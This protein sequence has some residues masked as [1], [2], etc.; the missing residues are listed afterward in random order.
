[1]PQYKEYKLHIKT[2]INGQ[3][4]TPL[5]LPMARL[6]EYLADLA[7]LF[8]YREHVHFLKVEEGSA[9]PIALVEME[10]EARVRER[11]VQ[12][13]AGRAPTDANRAYIQ[14]NQKFVDDDGYGEVLKNLLGER[15]KLSNSPAKKRKPIPCLWTHQRKHIRPGGIEASRG[16]GSH[17]SRLA[18][19]R[20]WTHVLLRC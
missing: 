17:D 9:S 19:R 7:T 3:E 14:L 15:L 13:A 1:M 11:M 18:T 6:A 12:A 4:V 2:K 5:N 20:R 10:R 16:S 8:G